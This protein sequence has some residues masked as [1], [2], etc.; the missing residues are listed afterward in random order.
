MVPSGGTYLSEKHV[1][2]VLLHPSFHRDQCSERWLQRYPMQKN[3]INNVVL[4]WFNIQMSHFKITEVM[5]HCRFYSQA[6]V[7]DHLSTTTTNF[8]FQFS[9]IYLRITTIW[10][11]WLGWSLYT[12]LTV[13]DLWIFWNNTMYNKSD[14]LL[15]FTKIQQHIATLFGPQTGWNKLCS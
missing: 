8:G 14:H 12:C 15:I 13:Y 7:N 9:I 5:E 1:F 11:L 4:H 3:V 10:Q 2:V 6:W